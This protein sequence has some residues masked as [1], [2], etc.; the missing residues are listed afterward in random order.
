MMKMADAVKVRGKGNAI[1][2][3]VLGIVGV[4]LWFF[5]VGSIVSIIT[6]IID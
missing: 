1:A 5:G 3:M 2:S 6:G 4:V